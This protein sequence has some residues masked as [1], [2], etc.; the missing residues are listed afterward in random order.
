MSI[1]PPSSSGASTSRTWTT[2]DGRAA[3]HLLDPST[4]RPAWTGLLT[5]TAL[6]P[7]TLEAET[8]AKVALLSGRP[9]ALPD[10]D[11]AELPDLGSAFNDLS[12]WRHYAGRLEIAGLAL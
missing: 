9:H 4:G 3:H 12:R 10:D 11:R 2:P 6:A 8:L 1:R 7:T 5:T